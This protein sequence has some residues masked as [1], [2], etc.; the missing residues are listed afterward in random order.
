MDVSWLDRDE[1]P[2]NSHFM[3]V[4]GGR[5]H[6]LDVGQGRPLV[7][8]HGTPTWSFLYRHFIKELSKKYRVI[9]PDHIGFGL[10][11]KPA[12]WSYRTRDHAANLSA[13]ITSLGLQNITLVV[14]D[15]GGPI[16]FPYALEHPQ[17]IHSLVIFNTFLWSLR[18]ERKFETPGLIF[19]N[20][21]GRWLYLKH[22][23]S[24]RVLL[25]SAWGKYK[26]LTR[27]IH[28]HYTSPF[29]NSGERMGTWGFVR[30]LLG[31]S[32]W[33]Q[34]QWV[35][36][37]CIADKP[38]LILWGMKDF[39]FGEK[40]LARWKGLFTQSRVVTYPQVGHFVPD[41]ASDAT[42]IEVRS[43]LQEL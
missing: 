8:V 22:N 25:K 2:F 41:E 21:V 13:L 32:E 14:H 20:P 33:Y 26:P 37:A 30:A 7:M 3:Q 6:Y 19:N 31:E 38:A 18:G 28:R 9:V 17:N 39:A 42:V 36:R 27:D 35:R 29:S 24:A 16:G 12:H 11:D 1:Y 4:E 43:F 10:S 40:E 5:M 23:F 34:S 15:F